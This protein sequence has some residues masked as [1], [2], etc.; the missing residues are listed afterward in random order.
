MLEINF[1]EPSVSEKALF[2]FPGTSVLEFN[3]NSSLI[4]Q[5]PYSFEISIA[6][7]YAQIH[8]FEIVI[9]VIL[10][11]PIVK[12]NSKFQIY[13]GFT[14]HT[15]MDYLIGNWYYINFLIMSL[16]LFET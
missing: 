9:N 11:C 4:Y 7:Y 14:Q 13:F 16:L 6:S 12:I 5:L 10:Y 3:L 2:A 8:H 1:S 15:E